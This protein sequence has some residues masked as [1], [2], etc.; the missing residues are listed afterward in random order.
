[1]LLITRRASE[2]VV[3]NGCIQ[4]KIVE[5][6]G[7]RVKLGFEYPPGNTVYRE[8]LYQ[9]IQDENRSAMQIKPDQLGSLL[10]KLGKGKGEGS[11]K[12]IAEFDLADLAKTDNPADEGEDA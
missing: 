10:Q 11:Q 1:M 4:V 2:S 9:K 8:E 5:I 6:R 3:I 7:S 12:L